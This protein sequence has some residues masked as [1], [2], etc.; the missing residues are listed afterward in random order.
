MKAV[1]SWLRHIVRN[2]DFDL[3]L[4]AVVALLFTILGVTGVDPKWIT[5]CVLALLALLAFSQIR[6]RRQ[7]AV[8]A[9]AQKL[10]PLARLRTE[11]PSD[12]EAQR[13]NALHVLLIG[14]SLSRTIQS[15]RRAAVKTLVRG[16]TV[17]ILLLDPHTIS[18]DDGEAVRLRSRIEGSL[19]ELAE[20]R[21]QGSNLEVRL[22]ER[23]PAVGMN[24]LDVGAPSGMIVVQHREFNPNNEA[25]PI[26][27]LRA[28]D[29]PWYMHFREEAERLWDSGTPWPPPAG[30]VLM[31]RMA[32]SFAL[33]FGQDYLAAIADA[34]TLLITG[35]ARNELVLSNFQILQSALRRGCRLRIVL[36]DPD[37]SAVKIAANRYYAE[38]STSYLQSRIRQTTGLLSAL[39][40]RTDGHVELRYTRHPLAIG[41]VG[42]NTVSNS[43]ARTLYLEYYTHQAA[44]EPK[45]VL[46]SGDD[47]GFQT[48]LDEAEVLWETAEVVDLGPSGDSPTEAEVEFLRNSTDPPAP[49]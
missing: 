26:L 27:V 46:N 38:R 11:F 4:M 5:A 29:P 18:S 17:R 20:I 7:V 24:V 45:F 31:R 13:A 22:L 49:N 9:D 28:A 41:C 2:D 44:N 23:E 48:F 36:L 1:G 32:P 15:Y 12:L 40:E 25:A 14:V 6:S 34:E 10:D 43:G 3:Y 19:D 30:A 8:I 21:R 33:R 39:K 35:V 47:P 42:V 16:G 37:C